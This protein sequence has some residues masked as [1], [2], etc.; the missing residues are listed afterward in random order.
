MK[1]KMSK[2]STVE[3]SSDYAASLQKAKNYAKGVK[4]RNSKGAYNRCECC[5]QKEDLERVQRIISNW[6]VK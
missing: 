6:K 5:K 3:T 4:E 2:T 1:L